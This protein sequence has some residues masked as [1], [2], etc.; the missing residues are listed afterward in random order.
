MLQLLYFTE[1]CIQNEQCTTLYYIVLQIN[2][3]LINCTYFFEYTHA[4]LIQPL[5][6]GKYRN[7]EFPMKQTQ[8]PTIY[9]KL[10]S[11]DEI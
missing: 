4:S 11:Y 5:G 3:P 10:H 2:F 8:Q 9:I 1:Y 7:I 6:T